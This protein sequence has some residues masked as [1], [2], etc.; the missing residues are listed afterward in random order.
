MPAVNS[1]FRKTRSGFLNFRADSCRHSVGKALLKSRRRQALF[2]PR[3]PFLAVLLLILT[4][5][6]APV[7]V[8]A[9]E[10]LQRPA[11]MSPLASHVLLT[12]SARLPSGR[13]IGV[14]LYGSIVYSDDQGKTWR[15]ARSPTQVLL[16][17]VFFLDEK[18]GWAGA[19]DSLILHTRDGGETWAIQH[20]DPIP[21]GD[22]PKPILDIHF[23]DS[24]T[25]YAIGAYG[26]MLET[27]D[28]GQ[29]WEEVDTMDLYDRLEELGMEPEPNFNYMIP[30]QDNILIVG[31]L[32]T[33][34][35][36]NPRAE[37]EEERW[38]IL[39]SPYEGTFFGVTEL[40]SGALYLY[41][42]RG[43]IYRTLDNGET[44]QKIKTGV[45]DNIYGC[46]EMPNGTIVFLG[47]GGTILTMNAGETTTR[48]HPYPGF[49]TIMKAE[50]VTG[51]DVLMFGSRGVR[52][53]TI[54]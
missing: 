49:D 21:G 33:I 40:S 47:S 43:N 53:F 9:E 16:T 17:N 6:S 10:S 12:D 45:I 44:W 30:F 37:T 41:G 4:G 32:G 3:I 18:L 39:E 14:G 11:V 7:P 36:F 46:T 20:E 27:G 52:P 38:R 35:V 19:H 25:G 34:L 29:T 24:D 2:T 13:Y 5:V 28:G 51:D 31:E 26:L 8:A 54:D 50:L 48:K 23:T 15:Q 42:L 1:T 22:I